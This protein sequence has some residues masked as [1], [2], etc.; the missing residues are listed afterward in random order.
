[1]A[2]PGLMLVLLFVATP[3]AGTGATAVRGETKTKPA[4]VAAGSYRVPPQLSKLTPLHAANPTAAQRVMP[5]L[6]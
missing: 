2:A 6:H 3:S 1:M 5:D 4:V